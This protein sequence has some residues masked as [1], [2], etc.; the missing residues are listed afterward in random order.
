M[1]DVAAGE[2]ERVLT[3][4]PGV[5]TAAVVGQPD[6]ILDEVPVAFVTVGDDRDRDAV[7]AAALATCTAQLAD[8][9]APRRVYV[10]DELPESLLG[11]IAKAALRDEAIRRM[12]SEAS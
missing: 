2:I 5:A 11:K 3:T 1:T 8:F 10:I 4:V 6:R 7:V 12:E 9:K